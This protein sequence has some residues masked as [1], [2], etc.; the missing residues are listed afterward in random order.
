[1]QDAFVEMGRWLWTRCKGVL[2]DVTAEEADWRPLPEANSIN[3]IVRHLRIEAEWHLSSLEDGAPMPFE[4]TPELQK[5][6]DAVPPDFER[7]LKELDDLYTRFL[8]ALARLTPAEL[9]RQT[10]LAYGSDR[11]ERG[12]PANFLG[13]HQTIHLAMHFGQITSIRNL[14]RRTRGQPGFLADN[15]T[16]PKAAVRE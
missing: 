11:L 12:R 16:F 4:T 9:E 5:A 10:A 8:S 15:P 1:M 7:N 14:Y 6:I 13:F 2:E 3:L